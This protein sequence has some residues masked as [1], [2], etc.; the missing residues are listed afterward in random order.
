TESKIHELASE[1]SRVTAEETPANRKRYAFVHGQPKVSHEYC[2]VLVVVRRVPSQR[3]KRRAVRS[4]RRLWPSRLVA[5][6]VWGHR[7]HVAAARGDS[8]SR[9]YGYRAR[10]ARHGTVNASRGRLR[11]D[12]P[13]T[14]PCIDSRSPDG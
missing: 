10:L 4:N 9:S 5:S 8:R 7:R 6:R 1:P 12:Q 14:R 11:E 13:G 3:R 2:A